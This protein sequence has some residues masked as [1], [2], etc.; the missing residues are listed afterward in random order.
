G[1]GLQANTSVQ[2]G[3]QAAPVLASSATQLLVDSKATPD[4]TYDVLLQDVS[5]GGSS[6]MT[7]ALTVGA[8]PSDTI[9]MVAGTNPGT[10]VGGRAPSPFSVR[11]LAPDGVTPIAGA[12]VLFSSS[13]VVG[14]SECDG[15]ASCSV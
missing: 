7:N 1:L 14:I 12:S 6:T 13:P 9:K 3:T 8:G 5:S 4:G 2:L 15:A 10:P 11:V